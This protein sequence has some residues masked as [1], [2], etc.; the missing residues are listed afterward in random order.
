MDETDHVFLTP[1]EAVA[2]VRMDAGLYGPQEDLWVGLLRLLAGRAR[3]G[4]GQGMPPPTSP[5]D[6]ACAWL[7]SCPADLDTLAAALALVF[8]TAAVPGT[9]PGGE[10]GIYVATGMDRFSCTRCGHCC[11]ILSFHAVCD[12]EDLERWRLAGREDILA[13]VGGGGDG[14]GMLWVRPGT[15]LLIEH[16]PW[17]AAEPDGR[18]ACIIHDL[19]PNLCR[20]FPGSAKHARLTGCPGMR[21]G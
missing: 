13:W 16:C 15:N 14:T 6:A 19:K 7:A 8:E 2:A 3:A 5:A 18:S 12:P 11:R 17:L 4:P 9:G 1:E 10:P 20:E 21:S